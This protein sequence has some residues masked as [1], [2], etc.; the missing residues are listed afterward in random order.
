MIPLISPELLRNNTARRFHEEQADGGW[1]NLADESL[2]HKDI[3]R[4]CSQI[5]I[6][7]RVLF[8]NDKIGSYRLRVPAK[9]IKIDH[10]AFAK[11]QDLQKILGKLDATPN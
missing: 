10:E 4:I 5:G 8:D 9:N 1:V 3:E 11:H 2:Y 7:R 6:L